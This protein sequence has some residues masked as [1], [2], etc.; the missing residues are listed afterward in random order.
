MSH[1]KTQRESYHANVI[2]F[3]ALFFRD[4][5]ERF[6]PHHGPTS[7]PAALRQR[8]QLLTLSLAVPAV[9]A[10]CAICAPR[11][12]NPRRHGLQERQTCL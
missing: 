6:R 1:A 11:G 7:G 12:S 5:R 9:P 2:T 4:L 3:I 10:I 8:K